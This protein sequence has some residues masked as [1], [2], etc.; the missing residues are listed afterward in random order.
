MEC[1]K[2]QLHALP[3]RHLS[4]SSLSRVA[5]MDRVKF[6]WLLIYPVLSSRLTNLF[7]LINVCRLVTALTGMKVISRTMWPKTSAVSWNDQLR[8]AIKIFTSSR[9]SS[10][11]FGHRY[12]NILRSAPFNQSALTWFLQILCFKYSKSSMSSSWQTFFTVK[13][14]MG[15]CGGRFLSNEECARRL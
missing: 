2:S 4:L 11:I 9:Y 5:I 14:F 15:V 1:T 8:A 3:K 12:S 6:N 13:P 10:D 7:F